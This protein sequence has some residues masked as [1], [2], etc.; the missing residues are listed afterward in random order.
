MASKKVWCEVQALRGEVV[1]NEK[2]GHFNARITSKVV[3]CEGEPG[4]VGQTFTE[5][6]YI[7]ENPR[8]CTEG[9]GKALKNTL[10]QLRSLGVTGSNLF[11]LEGLGSI[12][13]A[14]V[15]E[16]DTYKGVTRERLG[17]FELKKKA[18]ALEG[19]AKAD[20][21]DRFAADMAAIPVVDKSEHNAALS[22]D[23]LPSDQEV[24][25]AAVADD[26]ELPF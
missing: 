21:N 5:Y 4:R 8:D 10:R 19:Q 11:D 13:A 9:Q 18:P 12:R 1:K 6:L 25:R 3:A 20:F 15:I 2:S 17:V 7:P 26:D 24:E 14:G 22:D 16:D 23:D